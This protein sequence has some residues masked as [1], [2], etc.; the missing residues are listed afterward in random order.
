MIKTLIVDDSSLA[1]DVIR[2]FLEK[3][4]SFEI[5]D[6]A[7]DGEEAID[8]ILKLN[9]DLV[10]LDIEMPK[11]N[12][13][14][15]IEAVTGKC[16]VPIVVITSNDTAKMAYTATVLGALEFYSKSIFTSELTKEKRTEIYDTLKRI[17]S[18]KA[19]KNNQ[20]KENVLNI[21]PKKRE[22][23]AVLIASS[24]GGPKALS[25]VFEKIPEDFPVPIIIVQHNTRG[26]DESFVEWLG[27]FTKL[28]VKIAR[29]KDELNK[30]CVYIA[31]TD[32]HLGVKR[33]W[34]GFKFFTDDGE[35]ENN[36]KPAADFLFRTASECLRDS[37]IS[38]VLT[39]MGSDG[40]IGTK[41]IKERGGITLAQDEKS[42]LIYG[43]PKAAAETGCVDMVLDLEEIPQELI[44]LVS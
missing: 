13:L 5:I 38:V 30:G 22:I 18:L 40:A 21:E 44:K 33:E 17:T 42:S 11:K 31:H 24:T 35:A 1:R 7:C 34:E 10:T 32:I 29:D 6:E 27:T 25:S 41:F 16:N 3:D 19:G 15:V 39:G 14:Q 2:D 4:G 20:D 43:M 37:V 23:K 26:F 28:N 8:K 9:P 12:G 36:Q